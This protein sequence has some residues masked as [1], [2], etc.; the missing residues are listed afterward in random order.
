QGL[1]E[2][3]NKRIEV[4]QPENGQR[5]IEFG[6]NG[7]IEASHPMRSNPFY[8]QAMEDAELL[9]DAGNEFDEE[10]VLAGQLTPVF[11]GSALTDFG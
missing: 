1:Y 3:Y 4:Y 7:E 2:F 8:A 11:F 6:G 10:E 5:F 9:L